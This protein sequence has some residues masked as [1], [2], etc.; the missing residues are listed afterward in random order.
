[1]ADSKQHPL[2][3]LPKVEVVCDFDTGT[4][5]WMYVKQG[6]VY[7]LTPAPCSD[8]EEQQEASELLQL[9]TQRPGSGTLIRL[10]YSPLPPTMEGVKSLTTAEWKKSYADGNFDVLPSLSF[11]GHH[12]ILNMVLLSEGAVPGKGL[13]I[14]LQDPSACGD[15]VFKLIKKH[16][17]K[18]NAKDKKKVLSLLKETPCLTSLH[19]AAL[20]HLALNLPK[21]IK[22]RVESRGADKELDPEMKSQL[23][24]EASKQLLQSLLQMPAPPYTL[25]TQ[26][27][28]ILPG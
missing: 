19:M 5:P 18:S 24:A 25:P 20:S 21:Q 12:L 11:K 9:L 6:S 14:A 23:E 27:H 16:T 28:T 7:S 4:L 13:L 26:T 10:R 17:S 22:R 15:D 2:Y 3:L 1:M 8:L